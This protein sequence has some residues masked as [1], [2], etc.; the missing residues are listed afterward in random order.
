MTSPT[1]QTPYLIRALHEWC[2]DN[3]LTPHIAVQVDDSVHVPREHVKEGQ[4]VLN[5]SWDA[6]NTLQLGN[7]CIEFRARFGGTLRDIMVPIGRVI[8]IYARETMQGLTFTPQDNLE[9]RPT[10]TQKETERED[11]IDDID[12]DIPYW[13]GGGVT[14][15]P[16]SPPKKGGGAG[17]K[18]VK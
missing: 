15:S 3:G 14:S 10:T 1:S 7:E 5:I 12:T 9:P 18:R 8:A 16:P 11:D 2:S 4:I 17:L 13:L 6:T